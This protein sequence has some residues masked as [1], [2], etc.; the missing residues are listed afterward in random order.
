[1]ILWATTLGDPICP[2]RIILFFRRK[3]LENI[4]RIYFAEN[5]RKILIYILELSAQGNSMA[6]VPVYIYVVRLRQYRTPGVP[7]VDFFPL[8]SFTRA[9]SAAWLGLGRRRNLIE[10]ACYRN[11]P[12]SR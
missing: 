6:T 11:W 12:R 5:G 4:L 1:M 2:A 7:S 8:P 10:A 3:I 9:G